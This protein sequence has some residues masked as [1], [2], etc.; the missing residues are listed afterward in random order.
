[1]DFRRKL[2]A[3]AG[4]A[5][6]ALFLAHALTPLEARA[7]REHI[8]YWHG[9][10]AQRRIAITFDDG[11][12]DPYTSEI[13]KILADYR[14]PATFF[15]VGKNVA[16]NPSTARAIAAAGHVIG[17]HSWDHRNL[18]TKTNQQVRDEI[19][20]TQDAIEEATGIKTTLLRPPYGEKDTL[21]VH[22]AHRL[23]YV[24]V[25]WSVSAEDW[26]KPGRDRI[27]Q[28]VVQDV[29]N[30]SIILL[31]DGDKARRGD[32]HQTVE[33][34][35]LILAELQ[36]KGYEFVTVPELL[37]LSRRPAVPIVGGGASTVD[38]AQKI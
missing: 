23:G 28:N 18:V 4:L 35:P 12:N 31:H 15:L 22:E 21:T 30:G 19:L 2:F 7:N 13:L 24:T 6:S 11:P 37:H 32:R 34:L 20:K 8:L 1:M 10:S 36:K 26:R 29:R 9:D 25:E 5:G 27:V 38:P 14:V 33:A 16:A 17:N 3:C